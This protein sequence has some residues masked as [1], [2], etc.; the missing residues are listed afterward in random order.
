MIDNEPGATVNFGEAIAEV[1]SDTDVAVSVYASL[2]TLLVKSQVHLRSIA[3]DGVALPD[4]LFDKTGDPGA[5][6]FIEITTAATRIV[7]DHGADS[8]E[9]WDAATILSDKYGELKALPDSIRSGL[10][11]LTVH[12]VGHERQRGIDILSYDIT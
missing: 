11:F 2:V 7:H 9:A 4:G 5:D 1:T 3:S 12:L 10:M 8:R 6:Y